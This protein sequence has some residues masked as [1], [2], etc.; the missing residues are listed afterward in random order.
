MKRYDP[1]MDSSETFQGMIEDETGVYV[2]H[3]DVLKIQNKLMDLAHSNTQS[4]KAAHEYGD[5]NNALIYSG[6]AVAFEE[7]AN[8]LSGKK[9]RNR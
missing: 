2:E 5:T 1:Y 3:D 4:A 9:E 6:R 8:L 7:A